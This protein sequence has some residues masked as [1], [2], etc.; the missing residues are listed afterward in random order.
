[1]V[2][3]RIHRLPGMR[4]VTAHSY[5]QMRQVIE[6]TARYLSERGYS[7]IEPPLL[8]ETEL[9]VR[10]SGGEITSRLYTF[11]D[12]GGYKVSLRPEFT[13]SVIR[14][15]VQEQESLSTPVRWYYSGPVFRYEQGEDGGYRQFTQVGAELVGGEGVDADAEMLCIAWAGLQRLGLH[16]QQ[17]RIG[18]LGLLREVL[19]SYGLSEPAKLFI[20]SNVP[21]LKSG[22]TDVGALRE[23]AA[24]IGILR[25]GAYP[26][27]TGVA[28]ISR[29][30]AQEFIQDVLEESIPATV[31][32]RTPDQIVARM[33]RKVR[34][35]D[36]PAAFE[37][38]LTAVDRLCR[39]EGPP[40]EVLREARRIVSSREADPFGGVE[41]LFQ[42]L[43]GCD[44][45]EAQ[46]ALDLGLARGIA[47]YTGVVFELVYPAS[48]G[49]V[50]L[51]GGGRYD[52]LAKALGGGEDVPAL[53]FAYYLEQVV[54]AL[55]SSSR[56]LKSSASS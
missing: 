46:V 28:D 18:H 49:P 31:G 26:G 45:P 44:V 55:D 21:G 23:R 6:T 10:K 8:E 50:L 24:S 43:S 40:A 54:D 47:Y 12:P 2:G 41:A 1:M 7:A 11:T 19:A 3:S 27:G 56:P 37:D 38:A 15:F 25:G 53:G 30:A 17:L 39:L 34:D 22:R 9:F 20:I 29:G 35:P 13:S 4:D 32:R 14:Y 36:D 52:G 48:T 5:E 33:L 16:D 51:G 42:M